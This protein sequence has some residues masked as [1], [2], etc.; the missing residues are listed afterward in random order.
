MFGP[1]P[2]IC[3]DF[4][5][6]LCP[7]HRHPGPKPRLW[8]P[9]T[10]SHASFR[11]R[12]YGKPRRSH[13]DSV[14]W[15]TSWWLNGFDPIEKYDWSSN[16][17]MIPSEWSWVMTDFPNHYEWNANFWGVKMIKHIWNHYLVLL[18]HPCCL[19]I[20]G[21]LLTTSWKSRQFPVN[22][23]TPARCHLHF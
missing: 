2:S 3:L 9:L 21:F 12:I 6:V 13:S 17:I 4:F 19:V 7:A 15:K 23:C 5:E 18:F 16:W 22:V 10:R 1:K 20:H 11:S 14:D 8:G